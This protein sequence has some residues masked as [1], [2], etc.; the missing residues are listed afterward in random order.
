M[1]PTPAE[2]IGTAIEN[3]VR[4]LPALSA[5]GYVVLPVDLLRVALRDPDNETRGRLTAEASMDLDYWQDARKEVFRLIGG[6][7]E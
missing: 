3:R 5:A 6:T 2:V 1:D 4:V 7:D